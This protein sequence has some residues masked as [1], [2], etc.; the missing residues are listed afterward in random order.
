M[1]KHAGLDPRRIEAKLQD[2][3]R[4]PFQEIL[5]TLLKTKPDVKSLRKFARDFPDRWAQAVA[6]FSRISGYADK[7]VVEHN[8]YHWLVELSDAELQSIHEDYS[9]V[10]EGEVLPSLPQASL[11]QALPDEGKRHADASAPLPE[12]SGKDGA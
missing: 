2:L 7:S 11:D 5:A 9:K 4:Q 3:S 6:I 1:A 8:F 12:L 10:I